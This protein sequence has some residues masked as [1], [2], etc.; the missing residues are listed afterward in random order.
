MQSE[1]MKYFQ[2][3]NARDRVASD[4][5]F[6]VKLIVG[7][8]AFLYIVNLFQMGTAS[9]VSAMAEYLIMIPVIFFSLTFHEFSHAL[10]ADFLGDPTPRKLGRLSMNPLKHID[11]I[12]AI[13]LFVANFGWAKPV[14][15]NPGN[16]RMPARAMMSVSAAGPISNLL[17]AVIGGGIIKLCITL[18]PQLSPFTIEM[19]LFLG[20]TILI[21][22]LSLAFF[23]MIPIAPLDGSHIMN[24]FLPARIKMKLSFL[25]E[26]GSFL[27]I[28]LVMFGVVGIILKPLV[29]FGYRIIL[30]LYGF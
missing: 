26:M 7:I 20:K 28:F 6:K 18:Q 5:Y 17:L 9:A 30:S 23:N 16:F 15:V 12:G 22:N 2:S 19:G 10:M 21:M 24:Y 27:L 4:P 11:W 25:N 29:T 8:I 13:M 1:N 14:P 3:I